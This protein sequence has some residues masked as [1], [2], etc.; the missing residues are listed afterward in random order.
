[1]L[2]KA[3][4][5]AGSEKAW[6]SFKMLT[7]FVYPAHFACQSPH[8]DP[9]IKERIEAE[10]QD[11]PEKGN[12][13][14]LCPGGIRDVEFT[15]QCLQLLSGRVDEP[16]VPAAPWRLSRGLPGSGPGSGPL[17][18]GRAGIRC[19]GPFSQLVESNPGF[20]R[21][22]VT[23]CG[24]SLFLSDLLQRDSGLLD[25]LVAMPAAVAHFA[26]S[27]GQ[28]LSALQ[29]HRDQQLLR[30]GRRSAPSDDG[31]GDLSAPVVVS[32]RSAL[33]GL[34]H[35]R[36]RDRR[37][38]GARFACIAAGKFGG[39]ELTFGSD[40]NL[41]FVYDREGITGRWQGNVAFFTDVAQEVVRRLKESGL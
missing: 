21:M 27:G 20:R 31:A 10:V 22:L 30:I 12:N 34:R 8:R 18:T 15:V 16:R 14:K 25:G 36:P 1:M 33:P 2:I 37:G 23:I 41:F 19:S 3:R 26:L 7:P 40:L 17:R 35:G 6:R 4:R 13:I 39:R 11:R 29:R 5:S 9:Q 38:R 32:R 28:D 24:T